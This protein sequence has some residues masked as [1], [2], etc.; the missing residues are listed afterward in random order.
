VPVPEQQPAAD[1]TTAKADEDAE[2][3]P[4][5]FEVE[6]PSI[7]TPTPLTSDA[8]SDTVSTQPTTPSSPAP[9]AK[10]KSQE[11]PTQV[12]SRPVQP[13][14]VPV[15]PVLPASPSAARKTHR[16]SVVSSHSKASDEPTLAP[17]VRHES[18]SVAAGE[19]VEVKTVDAP[20][21]PKPTSWANLVRSTIPQTTTAMRPSNSSSNGVITAKGETLS[22]VLNDATAPI[23]PPSKISFLQPRG[24][25]NT[26]NMCYM[27]SVSLLLKSCFTRLTTSGIASPGLQCTILR[28]SF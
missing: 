9:T 20:P 24:L 6:A 3:R 8:P 13:V 1:I 7:H 16:D 10:I 2:Q 19:T 27:N 18:S 15:V 21:P 12:K 5:A 17:D 4:K 23:E 22:D 26:G 11:T 25:V 14:V 28:L